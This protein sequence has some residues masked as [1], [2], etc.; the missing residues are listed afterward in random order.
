M[1]AFTTKNF[2]VRPL[3]NVPVGYGLRKWEVQR[4]VDGNS[5]FFQR[6]TDALMYVEG[7]TY[8]DA[9]SDSAREF[10]DMVANS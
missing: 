9:L 10:W 3:G 6:L 2:E 4:L 8:W 7:V 1:N 5:I